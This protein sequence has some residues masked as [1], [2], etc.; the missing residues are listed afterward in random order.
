MIQTPDLD[1]LKDI[2]F[3]DILQRSLPIE[4]IEEDGFEDVY[5]MHVAEYHTYIAEDILVHNGG[6]GKGGGKGGGGMFK[7]IILSFI[8]V[9]NVLHCIS[10][11]V[12]LYV[13]LRYPKEAEKRTNEIFASGQ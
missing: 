3:I 12:T 1:S 10:L 4:K 8:P 11:I 5:N 2:L 13:K 9:I 6:G 7:G